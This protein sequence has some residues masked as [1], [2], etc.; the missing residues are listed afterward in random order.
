[1]SHFILIL[2]VVKLTKVILSVSIN[3]AHQQQMPCLRRS[4]PNEWQ[5]LSQVPDP[6]PAGCTWWGSS[7]VPLRAGA[8]QFWSHS[9]ARGYKLWPMLYNFF[10]CYFIKQQCL[11]F[12]ELWESKIDV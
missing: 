1:M 4:R 11:M 10:G 5:L 2:R 12:G 7:S 8:R 6:G 9:W 3:Q